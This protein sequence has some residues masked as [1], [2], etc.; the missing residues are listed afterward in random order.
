MNRLGGPPLT[1][2]SPARRTVALAMNLRRRFRI[3][4]LALAFY[5]AAGGVVS[6]FWWHAHHG[7]RGLQAKAGHKIRIVEL[8]GEI[9]A[10]RKEKGDWERRVAQLRAESLDRDLLEE[11][12]RILL[13][14]AHKNDVIV[15]LPQQR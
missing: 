1:M 13:N 11:R 14:G 4:L 6:Y 12:A 3:A 5:G 2:D 7:D 15:I 10:A 8:N 9:A